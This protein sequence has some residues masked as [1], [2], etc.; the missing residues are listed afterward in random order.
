[1]PNGGSV[2]QIEFVG[3]HHH[4]VGRIQRLAVELVDERGDGAVELGA[5]DPPRVVLAGDEAPL[6]VAGVA[7]GVVG[8]LAEHADA[9][10]FP[11]ASASCGCWE[12]RSRPGSGRRRTR[13][14]PRTSACRCARRSTLA[15]AETILGE[16]RIE[17]LDGGVGVALARPP[18]GKG[19][20][21]RGGGCK[22]GAGRGHERASGMLHG[23]SSWVPATLLGPATLLWL[24][25]I[26]SFTYG[27]VRP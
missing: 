20:R 14:A 26:C 16:A 11:P 27:T 15:S 23:A 7:V 4:V 18:L 13:P 6:A 8:R 19:R 12:C 24:E 10:V 21:G 5:R 2:N 22:R 9:A 1:M 17:D 3:F 25:G